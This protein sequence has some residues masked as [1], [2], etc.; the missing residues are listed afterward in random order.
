MIQVDP[1]SGLPA[2]L[3]SPQDSGLSFRLAG[4][5]LRSIRAAAER[6]NKTVSEWARDALVEAARES[7]QVATREDAEVG[8]EYDVAT[9]RPVTR[10]GE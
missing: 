2:A 6:A 5:D 8:V 7:S 10:I 9:G 1:V 3:R 4:G